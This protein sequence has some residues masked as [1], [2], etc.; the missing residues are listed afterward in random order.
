MSLSTSCS[1]VFPVFLFPSCE[2]LCSPHPTSPH[3]EFSL[4]TLCQTVWSCLRVFPVFLIRSSCCSGVPLV[5]VL[6]VIFLCLAF[7][8]PALLWLGFWILL[9]GFWLWAL[10]LNV[11]LFLN[12]PAICVCPVFGSSCVTVTVRLS[13]LSLCYKVGVSRLK[14]MVIYQAGSV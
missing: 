8:S 4:L 3:H 7:L 14:D 9:L 13:L 12:L 2:F 11:C 6:F 10:K 1:A 5:F